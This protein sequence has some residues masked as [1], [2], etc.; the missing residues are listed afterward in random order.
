MSRLLSF[1]NLD[2]EEE[3]ASARN[4]QASPAVLAAS[5]QWRF[6][7]RLLP[8]AQSAD[9]WERER[10]IGPGAYDRLLYWGVTPTVY[11]LAEQMKLLSTLPSLDSV[12]LVN[13]KR[14]SQQ[15]EQALDCALPHSCLVSSLSDFEHAVANCPHDWV[16]KHPL[17][18]SGRERAVGKREK[19]S[20]SALGWARRR[21]SAGWSLV[22][23]PWLEDKLERSFHF[24]ISPAGEVD[25]VG[26][27][28]LRSDAGGVYRG[29]LVDPNSS[30]EPSLLQGANQA[31]Q[32]VAEQGYWG[33]V[34]IDAMVGRLGDQ[35]IIR[36]VTEI[37]ARY[38][39]GRM[40]LALGQYVPKGWCY[41]WWHPRQADL[42]K[43]PKA[44]QLHRSHLPGFAA[45]PEWVDPGQASRTLV[46]IAPD[47]VTLE[48]L[49]QHLTEL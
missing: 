4:Y 1:V 46:L 5:H 26:E 43:V 9:Y 42:A 40:T 6:L 34:G 32:K 38:S 25:F 22:F 17:G 10:S 44:T 11:N 39:F 24:D 7:L 28:E 21:I 33:P 2:F 14:F 47:R 16:L 20:E 41:R 18:F 29:N 3:L 12:R 23:E 31:A 37:N 30:A 35:S 13:D 49:E 8:G 27:T 19:I 45:L 48:K 36:P 15:I